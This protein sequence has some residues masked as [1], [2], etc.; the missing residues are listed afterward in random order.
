MGHAGGRIVRLAALAATVCGL[1][2]ASGASAE[3]MLANPS[4]ELPGSGGNRFA[5]WSQFGSVGSSTTAAHGAVAARVSGPNTGGWSVS[6]YWQQQDAV[7]GERWSASGLVLHPSSRP[8]TGQSQAIVNVEWRDAGGNLISYESHPA[9]VA[10][11]PPNVLREFSFETEPAPAGTAA[12]RILLGVLQ[13]PADP[14]PDAIY[15]EVRFERLG[16][17]SLD[18]K[19]W[20][21]FPGGR[22]KIGR[23]HV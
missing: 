6:G 10:A 20:L 8:L 4:F 3:C 16:S 1:A 12:A 14:V 18:E 23:A 15:D 17:P 21:D 9:A 13:G 19:Q 22:T 11:T 7:P 2:L 5:G